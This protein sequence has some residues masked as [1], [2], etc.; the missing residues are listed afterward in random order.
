MTWRDVPMPEGIAALSRIG[1]LPIPSNVLIVDGKPDFRVIDV[2]KAERQA[3]KRLCA[4]CNRKMGQWVCFLG[5]PGSMQ[6]G[7]F[8]DGPMHEDCARY[9][10]QV[11][12]YLAGI[13]NFREGG[14]PDLP[15]G[16]IVTDEAIPAKQVES[17]GLMRTRGYDR[18]GPYLRAQKP[19][20][21]E[22]VR[23]G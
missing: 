10:A 22:I 14:Y 7:A 4:I 21:V 20:I 2:A 3:K 6:S 9:A 12:P 1:G 8:R 16:K 17:I 15:G 19:R 23:G 18:T 5:G 11:C 13:R